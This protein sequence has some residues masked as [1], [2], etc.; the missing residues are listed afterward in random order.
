MT[1]ARLTALPWIGGKSDGPGNQQRTG[2]WIASLLP[3]AEPYQTYIEPF[4]GMLGVLLQRAPAAREIVNDLDGRVINWWRAVRDEPD[5]L[6]RLIALTPNSRA[7]YEAARARLADGGEGVRA[8]LDFTIA[9]RQGM[10]TTIAPTGWKARYKA[11][12][13]PSW[14]GGVD[15]RLALL[16]DRMRDVV[17]ESRDACDLLD[18]TARVDQA[19]IYAD[20]PYPTA[21]RNL[22]S[23][24]VDFSRLA[25][26]LHA[27][28]GR[29]A[30]SGYGAEWDHL[31]W[32]RHERAVHCVGLNT[33]KAEPRTE[34]LWTNYSPPPRPTLPA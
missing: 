4:A 9:V 15:S 29:V 14:R 25:A 10:A 28:Q 21:A 24:D 32:L 23:E 27:Q 2:A 5:E 26:A 3:P 19:V 31:G 33:H 6:A 1:A 30:V 13:H 17:L 11:G 20:P 7:E 8:A 34:V 12:S 18:R 16:A 22:Y